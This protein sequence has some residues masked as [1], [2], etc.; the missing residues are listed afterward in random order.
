MSRTLI[1]IRHAHRDTEDPSRDNG[2]SEKGKAQVTDLVHYFKSWCN[3]EHEDARIKLM[4]SPK[5]RCIQ[6]LEPIAAALERKLD[7]DARISEVQFLETEVSVRE[8]LEAF[9]QDWKSRSSEVTLVCSHGDVIPLCVQMLTGARIG[10]KKAGFVQIEGVAG[11]FFLT[12][13]IQKI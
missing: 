9:L 8:R 4:C 12:A 5:K 6:T 7:V 1:F 2:L 11:D 10:I 13:L 3:R